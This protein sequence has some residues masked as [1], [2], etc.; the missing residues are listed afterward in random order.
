MPTG[1][2]GSRVMNAGE[3][4]NAR[5]EIAHGEETRA[6][7]PRMEYFLVLALL[8][9]SFMLFQMSVLREIRHTLST[10]F[11]LTPFLF[12]TVIFFIGVGS[13]AARQISTGT[14]AVL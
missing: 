4:G 10:L 7:T 6:P 14:R 12:S 13:C 3:V 9:F 8:A 2:R 1:H 11:T 5:D